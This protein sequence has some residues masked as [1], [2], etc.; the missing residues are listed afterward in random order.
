M[1]IVRDYPTISGEGGFSVQKVAGVAFYG[2]KGPMAHTFW[3]G[4]Q[5][6]QDVVWGSYLPIE[7]V[8]EY[9][10]CGIF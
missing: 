6:Q 8:F 3:F 10:H 1:A 9:V 2:V 7:F 5:N 4:A